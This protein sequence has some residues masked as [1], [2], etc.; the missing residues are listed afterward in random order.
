MEH[1][2]LITF[3]IPTIGRETLK[4]TINSLKNLNIFNWKAVIVFDGIDPNIKDEDERIKI[5]KLEKKLGEGRNSA[6]NVRNH[7]YQF[8]DTPWIG[9][10]DDDDTLNKYYRIFL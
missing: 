7:A 2:C 10:V 9:F 6:G 8:V 3:V 4:R 5:I 1:N